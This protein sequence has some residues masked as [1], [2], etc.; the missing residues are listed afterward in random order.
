MLLKNSSS[1]S[2]NSDPPPE[3]V[4]WLAKEYFPDLKKE[5]LLEDILNFYSGYGER[6]FLLLFDLLSQQLK[7]DLIYWLLATQPESVVTKLREVIN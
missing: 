4:E 5:Q 2:N 6:D 7:R 1:K 3:E